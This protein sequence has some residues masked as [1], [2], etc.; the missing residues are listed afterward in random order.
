MKQSMRD[1]ITAIRDYFSVEGQW[2]TGTEYQVVN[3]VIQYCIAGAARAYTQ[4]SL[5]KE[6]LD[7]GTGQEGFNDL[8][9]RMGFDGAGEMANWNNYE[10][11]VAV[12]DRLDRL[13]AKAA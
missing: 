5:G 1:M 13:L 3:G 2:T 12:V 11:R 6:E 4:G 9:D 7:Y 8:A 10:G